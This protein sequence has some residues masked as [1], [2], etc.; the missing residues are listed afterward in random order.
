MFY[1]KLEEVFINSPSFIQQEVYIL[2][3]LN[4][5]ILAKNNI[6]KSALENFLR[7]HAMKQLITEPTRI[8]DTSET[9]IDLICTSNPEQITQLGMLPCKISDHNIIFCTRKLSKV[10]YNSIMIYILE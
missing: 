4:T 7:I 10:H 1:S 8:T 9:A 5:D 2:G 3:D 6:L